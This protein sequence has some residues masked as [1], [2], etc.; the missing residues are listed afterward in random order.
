MMRSRGAPCRC[1]RGPLSFVA[2]TP[3]IGRPL[4]PRRI[5]RQPLSVLSQGGIDGG[6]PGAGLDGGREVAV[7]VLDHGVERSRRQQHV[8]GL[9]DSSPF[10]LGAA[11]TN[12][13]RQ[14]LARR[15]AKGRR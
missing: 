3:P 12:E 8:T 4:G 2:T 7:S 9:G 5:Q 11:A 1:R 14:L 6:Q 15:P 13:N 10:E